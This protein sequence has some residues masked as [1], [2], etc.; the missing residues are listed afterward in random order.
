[1]RHSLPAVHRPLLA[2]SILALA[3][4]AHAQ[5]K[6]D[7]VVTTATRTPQKLSDVLAD[8]TVLTRDDIERQAFGSL[9]DPLRNALKDR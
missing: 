4:S 8:M 7:T 6:L 5:N 9:A 1:M 2:L 3:A